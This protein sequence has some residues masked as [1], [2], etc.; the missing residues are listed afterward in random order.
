MTPARPPRW[1][2]DELAQ[3][4][5]LA[6]DD[7]RRERL[8]ELL[9]N[10]KTTVHRC[11]AQ[12]RR[13]FRETGLRQPVRPPSR[14]IAQLYAHDLGEPLRYLAAPPISHDD[15]KALAGSTLAPAALRR[16]PH[17]AR[18]VLRTLLQTLDPI[19][20]P[21]VH[22]NTRA[23]AS[24]WRAAIQATAVL[25]AAQRVATSRRHQGKNGQEQAAKDYLANVVGLTEVRLRKIETLYT[26]PA[27][28]EFCGESEVAGRKADIVVRLF[29]ARLLLIECKVSNSAL[30]SVKRV[31][32][33]AGAKASAWMQRL[34]DAQVVPAALLSGVFKVRNLEQAQALRLTLFWAHRLE[35]LGDF[36][37]A[38]R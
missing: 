17:A 18:N 14:V 5:A 7:F 29:D 34:G 8:G 6:L 28:G 23:Q 26:A 25:M 9:A 21:W 22:R 10:W 24:E 4:V 20:F 13:S 30:N 35:D 12:V 2:T 1:S 36:I 37:V 31:N 19:R 27:P 38:T 11:R 32:K 3:D 33:D 16:D 15:L